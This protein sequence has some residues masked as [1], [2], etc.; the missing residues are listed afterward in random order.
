MK[1]VYIWEG[2]GGE[3]HLLL[4]HLIIYYQ[5]TSILTGDLPVIVDN[6]IPAGII[7]SETPPPP[8]PPKV[9][10]D[11]DMPPPPIPRKT[12]Q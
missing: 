3:E 1:G 11:E 9:D 12:E 5:T 8:L 6:S 2:G 4:C 7:K 10:G